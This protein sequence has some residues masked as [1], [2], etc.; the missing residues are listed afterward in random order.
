MQKHFWSNLFWATIIIPFV[1]TIVGSHFFLNLAW[2]KNPTSLLCF[3]EEMSSPNMDG[4]LPPR[5]NFQLGACRLGGQSHQNLPN[6]WMK[7]MDKFMR[8]L[9]KNE[10]LNLGWNCLLQCNLDLR[11]IY[12]IANST[13]FSVSRFLDSVQ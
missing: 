8:F 10:H 3:L 12:Q 11:K 6:E 2:V 5:K 9:E 7:K 4:S 13:F 1:P